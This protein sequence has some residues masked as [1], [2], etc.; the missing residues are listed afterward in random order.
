MPSSACNNKSSARR[1]FQTSVCPAPATPQRHPLSLHDAL[2][3]WLRTHSGGSGY[4]PRDRRSAGR[5]HRAAIQRASRVREGQLPLSAGCPGAPRCQLPRRSEEHTSELQSHHDL[6]CRLLLATTKA[7]HAA[8]SRRL[9]ALPPRPPSAT[10][11]PYTTLFRSGFERIREVLDTHREIVDLPGARTAPPFKGQVEF[12]K[13]N[14][15]YQPDVPVLR[16]VSFRVDRKSTRLN[17]SHITISYAVFCL[18]QQKLRTP[19]IPDVC[20][21][22][23]RDPPAPPSF[24]TRRSS[25]LASN[26]F[27]RFW[28]PTARSSICRARAPRRHSKGKSSSRRSTSTISRM[29]RCSAMSASA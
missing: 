27:G 15:H 4:P 3:I 26:A 18:Q 1:R 17:S 8:D 16:D 12:E 25:D 5:A 6:V 24:P 20:L 28:I 23:P 19:P 22:C 11:F 14:F 2:P 13:V 9:S 29:S 7:P 21:P 10:L